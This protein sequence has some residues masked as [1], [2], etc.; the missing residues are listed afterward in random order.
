DAAT[1][2]TVIQMTP[3]LDAGPSIGVDRVAIDPDET[4]GE[5]EARLSDRGAQL[6][7]DVVDKLAAGT[8][9][10][11]E[12][13]KSQATKAPRL[14]KEQGEVDWSRPAHE[15]K[16]QVRAL[17][18]WP[19]AYTNWQRSS[20]E[21]LRL[22]L[23]RVQLAEGDFESASPGTVVAVGERLIVATGAGCLSL[24]QI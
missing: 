6:V 13:D 18:P 10:P 5:L 14:T 1:G 4:A 12:Q 16:N 2:S 19:R 15:I 21:P 8:V 24:E 9:E 11:I 23:D 17:H 22:I 7:L 3:G 20:G